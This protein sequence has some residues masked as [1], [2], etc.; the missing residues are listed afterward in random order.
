MSAQ[1]ETF[2]GEGS[3]ANNHQHKP[4]RMSYQKGLSDLQFKVAR[5]IVIASALLF[6]PIICFDF[7]LGFYQIG[8]LKI[9]VIGIFVYA[10]FRLKK[11]GFQKG[12]THVVNLSVLGFM[13]LNYLGNQGTNG[14]SLYASMAMFVVYPILLSNSWKWIYALL[15]IGFGI[16]LMYFGMDKRNLI[17]P[18]YAS[19]MDQFIDVSSSYA[20]MGIYL[21]VLVSLVIDHYKKQNL[22][23]AITHDQLKDQ[24][25]LVQKEKLQKEHLL[26]ILAHDVKSPINNLS[27]LCALYDD[28]LVSPQEVK[29]FMKAMQV[30]M[31]DVQGTID[32]ILGQLNKEIRQVEQSQGNSNPVTVTERVLK[33]VQ[34]KVDA[35][36]QRVQFQHAGA[37]EFPLSLNEK[38]NEISTILKNLIDN[39]HKYSPNGSTITV[40]LAAAEKQ[41]IWEVEDEGVGI[42]TEKQKQLF[43]STLPSEQGTGMG[44]YLCQSI[45]ASI[46]AS[47]SYEPGKKGSLFRLS[48]QV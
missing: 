31:E 24:I 5:T 40:R 36:D 48:V 27:Q 21:L 44:L 28:N 29:G 17:Q 16:V 12:F 39:A 10:Y 14:P 46:G 1:G 11:F 23:L 42:A 20:I 13:A 33:L 25:E 6:I 37:Q 26:G 41:L 2:P 8:L 22:N 38:A 35:K 19:P 18:E 34:Y 47:I 30:R 7:S 43:T 3:H 32:G 9:P 45:A 15:T 4:N